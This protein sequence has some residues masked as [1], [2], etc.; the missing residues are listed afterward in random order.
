[1][2]PERPFSVACGLPGTLPPWRRLA[3]F[4]IYGMLFCAKLKTV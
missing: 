4:V 2:F 3:A 1:M